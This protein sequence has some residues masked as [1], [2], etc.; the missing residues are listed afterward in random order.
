MSNLTL[1]RET[2]TLIKPPPV[3][4]SAISIRP[5]VGGIEGG[6]FM[7]IDKLQKKHNKMVGFLPR[8]QFEKGFER[9]SILIAEAETAN[10]G[11]GGGRGRERIGY[12]FYMD[13]YRMRE[14]VGIVYQLNVV[15]DQ[16]RGLVGAAL[17]QAAMDRC[18]R[19]VKLFCCYCAQDIG[20]NHFWEAIGFVPLAF[21]TGSR[22]IQNGGRRR[23]RDRM[24]IFWQKRIHAGDVTTPYWMPSETSGGAMKENRVVLPIP[25]DRHWSE[26]MPVVLPGMESGNAD[27]PALPPAGGA[28]PKREKK[29]KVVARVRPNA[30]SRGG[31]R[32]SPVRAAEALKAVNPKPEKPKREKQKND[33]RLLAFAREARDLFIDAVNSGNLLPSGTEPK[34]DVSRQLGAA[35]IAVVPEPIAP[36]LLLN[37]A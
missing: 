18:P 8:S 13:K 21:R 9:E 24:Q 6:D 14:E 10:G 1:Q 32:F 30:I 4:R 22:S 33:P 37:A 34:Y 17:V 7:F 5:A 3:P 20:A 35:N 29:P 16:H 31:L 15:P 23:G 28:K 26:E 11:G 25:P 36:P 19:G 2:T 12:I 27:A